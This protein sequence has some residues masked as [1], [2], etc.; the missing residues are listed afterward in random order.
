MAAAK[1]IQDADQNTL[2]NLI[3]VLNAAKAQL[4]KDTTTSEAGKTDTTKQ[5][6]QIVNSQQEALNNGYHV[7]GDKVINKLGKVISGWSV[8]SKGEMLDPQGNVITQIQ[9]IK[10]KTETE[11]TSNYPTRKGTKKQ[12]PQTGN[13]NE[14][15]ALMAGL[16]M[17]AGTLTTALGLN[18]KHQ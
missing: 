11:S 5:I 2:D 3:A 14:I 13:T 17:L 7:E 12:L 18:K 8:N 16:T 10:T 4:E 6:A 9:A 15:G 1:N